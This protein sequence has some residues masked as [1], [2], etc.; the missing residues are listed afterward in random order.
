MARRLGLD[1]GTLHSKAKT[2]NLTVVDAYVRTTRPS[3][4]NWTLKRGA[5]QSGGTSIA[6]ISLDKR[7]GADQ[8]SSLFI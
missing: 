3:G 4:V 6:R 8:I 7:N 2:K 1:G 5:T